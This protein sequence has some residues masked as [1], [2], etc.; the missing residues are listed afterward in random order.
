MHIVPVKI[1]YVSE[2]EE[3][4]TYALLD[5]SSQETFVR[6]DIIYILEVSGAGTKN[7][8]KTKNG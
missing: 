8:V 5:N 4:T 7:T 1:K 2:R 6:E 3:V